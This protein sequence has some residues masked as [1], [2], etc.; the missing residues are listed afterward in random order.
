[1]KKLVV[2]WAALI[3]GSLQAHADFVFQRNKNLSVSLDKQEALIVH[4]ALGML[5]KITLKFSVVKL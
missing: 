2:F 1:M 5:K 3:V 4:T